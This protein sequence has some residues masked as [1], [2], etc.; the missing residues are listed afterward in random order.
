M[1]FSRTG[2]GSPIRS[3]RVIGGFVYKGPGKVHNREGFLWK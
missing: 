1:G 3:H 2:F